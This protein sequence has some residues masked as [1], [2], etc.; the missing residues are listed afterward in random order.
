MSQ[1]T[2]MGQKSLKEESGHSN[3]SV[4]GSNVCSRVDRHITMKQKR[5]MLLEKV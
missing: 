2:S 4:G 5:K 3:N 1:N